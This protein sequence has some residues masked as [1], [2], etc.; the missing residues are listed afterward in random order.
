METCWNAE[1]L[2]LATRAARCGSPAVNWMSRTL[3]ICRWAGFM[4]PITHI[5]ALCSSITFIRAVA[6]GG[7]RAMVSFATPRSSGCPYGASAR[8]GPSRPRTIPGAKVR[9]RVSPERAVGSTRTES[10]TA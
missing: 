6:T 8:I 3:V 5:T 2:A 9:C 1:A 10:R 7:R 4:D